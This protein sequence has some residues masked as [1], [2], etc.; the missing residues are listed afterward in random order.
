MQS[1]RRAVLMLVLALLFRSGTIYANVCVDKNLKP[2][3]HFC[4][5]VVD[6]DGRPIPNATVS[7]LQRG[8][9]VAAKSTDASGAFSFDSLER[10]KY[11]FHAGANGFA[12][13]SFPFVISSPGANCEQ[14]VEIQLAVGAE[15]SHV[16]IVK[17]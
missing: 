5:A 4:G 7:V 13:V 1:H 15:C 3:R 12:R 6:S 2:L 9:E 10:G 8:I 11:E 17:Q 16:Q 14:K